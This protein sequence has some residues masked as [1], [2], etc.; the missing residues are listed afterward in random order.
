MFKLFLAVCFSL[1]ALSAAPLTYEQKIEELLQLSSLMKSQYGPYDYKR[2]VLKDSPELIL[3]RYVQLAQNTSNEEFYYLI[4][5]F[6]G[7]FNDS[8]FG[9]KVQTDRLGQ[10]GFIVER[11]AGKVLVDEIDRSR[12]SE[13]LFPFQKGDELVAIG[14]RTVESLVA[15][16]GQYLGSGY[17]ETNLR[18]AT[19]ILTFR[20][21]AGVPV[22]TGKT[23]VT[24]KKADGAEQTVELEWLVTGDAVEVN[25]GL[26]GEKDSLRNSPQDGLLESTAYGQLSIF[27]IY[28][29]A[30][31]TEKSFRCSGITRT[32]IPEGATHL[33]KTPFVAY[34]HPTPKGNVGYLRIPHYYWL[35]PITGADESEI[36]FAQYEWVI[37]QLEKKTMGL[38]I[39]QDH[40]CGGS[41]SY[42]EKMV[43]LFLDRPFDGLQFQFLAS[44]HEYLQF[45]SWVNAEEKAT[46][47][48][49]D[50]LKVLDLMKVSFAK[51]ER[52]TPKTTFQFD[53]RI[54]PNYIR[55]T[56]PIVMLI[57]ELSGSGGDAFPAMMQGLRRAKLMGTRTMGAG[58]HVI[59]L[60]NALSYSGNKLRLT[61]SLFY[62]P[63]GT[64]IENNG[65]TPD[66]PYAITKEDFL[67]GYKAY[68]AKYLE[69]LLGMI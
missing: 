22:P 17:P 38:I 37:E 13:T 44:R 19:W 26:N 64:A 58:G 42:L 31:R 50:F 54:E 36:R 62:H 33:M 41:V 25:T 61:K 43:S 11:V 53:R 49:S 4:N 10:L 34:Y 67:G 16:L 47:I 52:L 1:A 5:R 30:P 8:H 66:V 32:A 45:S 7:E 68:Q 51:G 12:L 40:N 69:L 23:T 60:D 59:E 35:N 2:T 55:Y 39:D 9:S 57:D 65:V 18:R 46:V 29:N 6:V 24:L 14:G 21:G 20:P 48:G 56:K 28:E 63:N 27:D 3:S 15:E